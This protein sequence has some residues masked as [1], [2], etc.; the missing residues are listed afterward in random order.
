MAEFVQVMMDW[1]RMCRSCPGCEGCARKDDCTMVPSVRDRE[2]V[3]LI[4]D[5][6]TAWAK[7]HP[8]P[9]YP[10]WEEWFRSLGV[11]NRKVNEPIPADI[12]EKI[13]LKPK[14]G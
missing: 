12:A 5:A 14:E 1:C 7:E 2:S 13:G 11:E 3:K 4:E 9:V 6:V 10:T 8:A